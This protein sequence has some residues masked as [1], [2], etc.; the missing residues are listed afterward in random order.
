MIQVLLCAIPVGGLLAVGMARLAGLAYW[1]LFTLLW[2]RL[3]ILGRHR[4][5]M[6]LL[7]ALIPF[8]NLLRSFAPFFTIIV[9]LLSVAAGYYNMLSPGTIWQVLQ[10]YRMVMWMFVFVI[11]Y[12]IWSLL[13]TGKYEVTIRIFELAFSVLLILIL[14]RSREMLGPAIAGVLISA[15]IVGLAMLPHI[16]TVAGERLG[17]M[18]VQGYALGNP[19]Q[20]GIP[21]ALSFLALIVDR[22]KWLN[23]EHHLLT[24]VLLLIP[25]VTLLALTTSRAS[26][27][28]AIGGLVAT[29]LLSHR[30]RV[31]MLVI[32]GFGALAIQLV[33]MSP[34]GGGLQRGIERTFGEDRTAGNRTSGRSDQWIVSYYA[35]TESVGRMIYGFGPGMGQ[36]VY[37][38]YSRRIPTVEFKVGSR[39]ALHSLYM[40]VGVEAG[41]IGLVPLLAWLLMGLYRTI[42]WG[43]I[44][45]MQFPLVCFLGFII[46]AAT[47]SGFDTVSGSLLGVGL[48]AT[49]RRSFS[50]D[51][52]QV[53]E[54][55]TPFDHRTS[56]GLAR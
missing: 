28:V 34:F 3:A 26:W 1:G 13:L 29:L 47:T 14:G 35:F 52:T 31:R 7:I 44:Y 41:L 10:R 36:D 42:R 27:L 20:L 22:G 17:E 54:P 53:T 25:T 18:V 33:L 39:M 38:S 24:R 56:V 11:V 55:G 23:L 40:Q 32:I 2:L 8:T 37:A 5:L 50:G 30:S 51:L 46:V 12:Y 15:C 16:G 43:L 49:S 45:G 9:V 21:L 48:L 19:V 4:E 6:A